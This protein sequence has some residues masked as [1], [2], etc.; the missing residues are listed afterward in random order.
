MSEQRVINVQDQAKLSLPK[1]YSLV[2]SGI[3]HR[4]LRSTLTMSVILLA[5]AFFMVSLSE[6]VMINAVAKGVFA[7]IH[8]ERQSIHMLNH[9]YKQKNSRSMSMQLA[10]A[11]RQAEKTNDHSQ[12]DEYAAVTG[13]DKERLY[14][15]ARECHWE[16]LYFSFFNNM[17]IGNR[18]MLIGNNKGRDIFTFLGKETNFLD[19]RKNLE[20]LRALKLPTEERE[21]K[22]L[23]A[24]QD[25]FRESLRLF[26][27]DWNGKIEQLQQQTQT[28][29]DGKRVHDWLCDASDAELKQWQHM[30]NELQFTVEDSDMITLQEDMRKLRARN[31]VT[32]VLLTP[33]MKKE[34]Q[35]TFLVKETLN[36][37]LHRLYSEETVPL[38][39]KYSKREYTHEQLVAVTKNID[40]NKRLSLLESDL[41]KQT[42]KK[43][44]SILSGRQT[45]L[46]IIS[47]VVCMVGIANAMLMAIT[48]RFREIATMKCLG[49]TDSFILIQFMMEAAIQGLAGGMLGMFVG[50]L[51]AIIKATFGYGLYP[52]LYFPFIAVVVCALISL[53]IGIVLAI[54]ASLYPSWAASR[55]APM[56][57]MRIE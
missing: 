18:K 42:A 23:I 52:F 14:Q 13:W 28:M 56:E 49:A 39:N 38:I 30:L 31:E 47:F 17:S 8:A 24:G 55:M 3:K 35:E 25:D 19:F 33:E 36:E 41:R 46:L 51:L 16:Q 40:Y 11:Y 44:G 45:F 34:W 22:A 32:E 5:V 26:L 15:L 1:V 20:P 43:S 57:A 2:R 29:T 50:F 12:L 10:E 37:M 48:E 53:L 6:N 9:L 27:R 54:I 7:E 4:L 21:L